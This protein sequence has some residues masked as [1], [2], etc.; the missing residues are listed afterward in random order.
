MKW[1]LLSGLMAIALS[2][3]GTL[4]Q[5]DLLE[6][7]VGYYAFDDGSG[8]VLHQ[9]SGPATDGDLYNFP[10][11]N[12]QWVAGQ[13]G[14]SLAFDGVDD[15][16]IVPEFPLASTALSVSIWGYANDTPAWASLVKNW[17]GGQVGQFHFGLGPG[18]SD[19]LN[20][21][22]TQAD[23]SAFNAGTDVEDVQT[24][25]WEHFA[26]VADPTE[27]LVTLYR[28]GEVV[29][30]VPYDGTFTASPNSEAI[31]IGV[32]TSDAGDA[33]DSG[34]PAYWNGMLDELAIWHRALSTDE[35]S[36]LYV[37][38]SAGQ[39]FIGGPAMPGDFDRNGVLDAADID[40]LSSEVRLG[41]NKAEFDLNQDG[42]VN[43]L[44]R[45]KWVDEL[46]HTYIGD[47]NFDG[48]FSSADFVTVFQAGQYEDA[49]AGNSGWATGDWNGDTEFNSSDFVAAFQLGSYEAGPRPA[50]LMVPEPWGARMLLI[51][52]VSLLPFRNRFARRASR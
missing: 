42:Q 11:D 26:F 3:C 8:S 38:G 44:D 43:D 13:V 50:A 37:L 31:G 14:G 51:S 52:G 4:C 41:T 12:S 46:K 19:T 35:I 7:L 29:N 28:N 39:S 21:F 33:A 10:D 30:Q 48:E 49:V 2:T 6:E 18:D 36:S 34:V 5:A 15:Y 24:E 22:V 45:Y 20:V 9:G 27:D 32:K 23:G 47:S 1:H 16:V 17:G 40:Q 25:T